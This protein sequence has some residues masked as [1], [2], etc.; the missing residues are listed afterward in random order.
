MNSQRR[1]QS[2]DA[3]KGLAILAVIL[4]HVPPSAMTGTNAW[5]VLD[6][7]AR[8]A[9]PCFFLIS[10]YFFHLSWCRA[11][12]KTKPLLN[13][14]A[15][16]LP[17]FLFW[18]LIYAI[19]LPH[20]GPG[21]LE[22][23]MGLLRYPHSF[24]LTGKIYHLWFL[25]SLLQGLV[26]LW[27][28]LQVRYLSA[29]LLVGLALFVFSLIGGTYSMT[30]WGHPVL[31]DM[32]SGPFFSTVFIMLG[33]SMAEGKLHFGATQAIALTIIG[34]VVCVIEVLLLHTCFQAPF[35][36]QSVMLGTLPLAVGLMNL[37][38]LNKLSI[39]P[40]ALIGKYSLGI[41]LIHPWI[42]EALK[43]LK[44]PWIDNSP[45]LIVTLTGSASLLLTLSLSKIAYIR[46]IVI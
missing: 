9:V 5:Q 32:K 26:I 8:F 11:E 2:V 33:A 20:A 42:I 22:N 35:H 19:V 12:N 31:F 4:V 18:A 13:S 7:L 36:G 16:I 14:A 27:V 39:E 46:K 44:F 30:P 3:L 43:T 1:N 38:L 28:A 41:Y 17:T 15:R 6:I 10:G 34:S 24:I 37:A 21:T 29:G 40:L 45:I 23:L 25:S